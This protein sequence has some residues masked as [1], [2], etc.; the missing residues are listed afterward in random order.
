VLKSNT[1]PH[2]S[3]GRYGGDEFL[4]VQPESSEPQAV[5]LVERLR[6]KVAEETFFGHAHELRVS[7]SAGIA[8]WDGRASA[9]ALVRC[10]QAALDA[11]KRA[12][13][14]QTVC[15]SQIGARP[16]AGEATR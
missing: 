9:E 5:A 12:G 1:R 3:V 11:A 13:R 7:F 16:A 10:A 6:E 4:I 14:R 8:A 2:D 15:S